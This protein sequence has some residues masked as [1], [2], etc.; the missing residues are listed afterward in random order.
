MKQLHL[1]R[2]ELFESD[3]ERL[4]MYLFGEYGEVLESSE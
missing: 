1:G 4:I 2:I 3:L